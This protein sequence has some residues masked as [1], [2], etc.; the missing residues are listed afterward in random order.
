MLS[1]QEWI[2]NGYRGI[3]M[4]VVLK[5]AGLSW[6]ELFLATC[7]G[8]ARANIMNRAAELAFWFLL[9]FFP[10][11]VSVTGMAAMIGSAPGSQGVLM[12]HVGEVLPSAASK[13]VRQ[14]LQQTTGTGVAWLSLLFALWSSASATAGLIDTLNAIYGL[15]DR[16]PWWKARLVAVCLAIAMGALLTAALIVV[17]Y[18]P[19]ILHKIAP[20]SAILS[21]WK[22]AQWPGAAFL[23][24]MALLSIYRFAPNI[25]EQ[26]WKWLLPGSI[27]AAAIWMAVSVLF[28]LYVRQFSH[29]GVLYGS[30]GALVI[31]MFWFYLS[32]AAILAGGELNAILEDAAAKQR[33]PG[34]KRRGQRSLAQMHDQNSVKL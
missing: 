10:M 32:G 14:V 15:K 13:L 27:L 5:L 2:N 9:G 34:A 4:A 21:V 6:R 18:V 3:E 1:S 29:F 23:I 17:A 24:I 8:A 31:L 7:R 28:K 20:G 33:V 25:Q 26:E 19:L 11:L 16:R 12:R 22:I 30:L